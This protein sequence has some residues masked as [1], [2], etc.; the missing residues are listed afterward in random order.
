MK[1]E[2]DL[3]LTIYFDIYGEFLTEKQSKIFDL[4]YNDDYSLAEIAQET[5]I[6]RQGVLDSLK[7]AKNKLLDMEKKLGL[8]QKQLSEENNGI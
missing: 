7:R 6:T 2:K 5:N 1:S 8:V 3:E 4:Y